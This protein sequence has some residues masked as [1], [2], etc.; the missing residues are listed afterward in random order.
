MSE[1]ERVGI[2]EKYTACSR[3]LSW[4]HAKD[5]KDCIAAKRSCGNDKGGG[6]KCKD[7]H[8]RMVCGSGNAYCASV[9]FYKSSVWHKRGN[10]FVSPAISDSSEDSDTLGIDDETGMLLED[11]QLKSG[12][13]YFEGRNLWDDGS[14]RVL[15]RNE[16]ARKHKLRSQE[17]SYKIN[18]VGGSD[19]VEKGVTYEIEVV[20]NSGKVYPIWGFGMDVIME[21]L[22][23]VDL[24][25]VRH[26]FP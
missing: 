13:H 24:K 6:V 22:D 3:Y 26:L 18:V 19:I 11:I 2:S 17:V 23:P 16:F 9:K 10:N 25:P 12:N 21:P 7:D 1:K 8:S 4:L 14:T 5:S 15:I 20:D